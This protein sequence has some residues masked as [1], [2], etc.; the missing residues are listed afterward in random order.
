[1]EKLGVGQSEQEESDLEDESVEEDK[2][3][4]VEEKKGSAKA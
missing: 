1:M 4:E 3:M 2:E